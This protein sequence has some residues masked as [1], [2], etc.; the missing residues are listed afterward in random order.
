MFHP[1]DVQRIIHIQGSI[2]ADT[3]VTGNA[4]ICE[5]LCKLSNTREHTI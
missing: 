4:F 1:K 3:S 2:S 5:N